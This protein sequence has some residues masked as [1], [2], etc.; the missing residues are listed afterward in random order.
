MKALL[1]L[2]LLGVSLSAS[3]IGHPHNLFSAHRKAK[4][5]VIKTAACQPVGKLARTTVVS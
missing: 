2:F 3:A 4:K 5:L 1:I